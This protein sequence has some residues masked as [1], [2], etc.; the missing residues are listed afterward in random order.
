MSAAHERF[1]FFPAER[2]KWSLDKCTVLWGMPNSIACAEVVAAMNSKWLQ[3]RMTAHTMFSCQSSTMGTWQ[4]MPAMP[5][6]MQ[7]A[8]YCHASTSTFK[9]CPETAAHNCTTVA[10]SHSYSQF[11]NVASYIIWWWA[12]LYCCFRFCSAWWSFQAPCRDMRHSRA[13]AILA[14]CIDIHTTAFKIV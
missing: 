8:L 11:L 14:L 9:V 4:P 6:S 13:A 7:F 3:P 12:R 2:F 10:Y 1:A 5:A